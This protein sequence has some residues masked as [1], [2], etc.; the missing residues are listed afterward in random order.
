MFSY[1]LILI[2]T[3]DI[4]FFEILNL[5][6]LSSSWVKDYHSVYYVNKSLYEKY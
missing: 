4:Y 5:T 3:F 1:S 6:Y 2:Y